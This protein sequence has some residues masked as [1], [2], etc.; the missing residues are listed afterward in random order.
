MHPASCITHSYF[1]LLTLLTLSTSPASV[2]AIPRTIPKALP[3]HP[4]NI[5]LAGEDVAVSVPASWPESWQALDYDGKI[6][7]QGRVQRGRVLLGRLPAGYYEILPMSEGVTNRISLG[8]LQPL[9]APTPLTSPIGIDVAMAWFYPK[10]KMAGVVNLCTLAGLNRVRD[11]L[12]WGEME[13]TRGTFAASNRYDWSAEAQAAA[14][15]QILQVNHHSPAWANPNGKRFPLDL[16]DCYEFYRAM[17]QRWH[18]RVLAFEPWNEADI[19]MFG[20]HTGSEMASLQ[21]ADYLG[22]Q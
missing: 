17:A 11:R 3:S 10:E 8:V 22:L 2:P 14:G 16:R 9:R 1:T 7:A 4:G 21:K 12:S 15:L 13:P 5:F 20:G 18:G 6:S 19:D